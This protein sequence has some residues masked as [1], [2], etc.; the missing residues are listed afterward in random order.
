MCVC[1]LRCPPSV[2]E[3]AKDSGLERVHAQFLRKDKK[4]TVSRPP[5]YAS[6]LLAVSEDDLTTLSVVDPYDLLPPPFT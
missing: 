4:S 1:C 2:A 6:H 3:E 5:S